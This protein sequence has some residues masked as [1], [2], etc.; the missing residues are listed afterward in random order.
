VS[1][2]ARLV[3]FESEADLAGT[4]A[5]TGIS[6]VYVYDRKSAT[7]ARITQDPQGCHL[8]SAYKVKHDWRIAYV[9]GGKPYFT[10]LRA[11]R[12]F[13]VQADGGTT[14]RVLAGRGHFVPHA[15]R[16]DER[17]RLD[18]RNQVYLVNLYRREPKEARGPVLG[19]RPGIPRSD[20]ARS[21]PLAVAGITP[22]P[23]PRAGRFDRGQALAGCLVA[24]PEARR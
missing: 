3:V 5:N 14:Q 22:D 24:P 11:N 17:A 10:M 12:R 7:Y 23:S 18:T 19:S 21:P 1:N 6:Q 4:R 2:D 9:C 15:R 13:E 8:P 20:A 16:L